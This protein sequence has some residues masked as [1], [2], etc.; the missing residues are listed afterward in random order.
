[1][2]G[3]Y[4]NDLFRLENLCRFAAEHVE[5]SRSCIKKTTKHRVY[6]VNVRLDL[7]L[8]F[9]YDDL[10][11]VVDFNIPEIHWYTAMRSGHNGDAFGEKDGIYNVSAVGPLLDRLRPELRGLCAHLRKLQLEAEES[12]F[13][14]NMAQEVLEG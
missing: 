1:M 7:G 5:S 6:D 11:L 3:Q 2:G 8:G 14:D 9:K 10:F 13:I 12:K 4:D